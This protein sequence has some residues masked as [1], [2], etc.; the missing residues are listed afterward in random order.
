VIGYRCYISI[1]TMPEKLQTP[2]VNYAYQDVPGVSHS[3]FEN[4]TPEDVMGPL[5]EARLGAEQDRNLAEQAKR[6]LAEQKRRSAP[7]RTA[8]MDNFFATAQRILHP[9]PTPEPTP[10]PIPRSPLADRLAEQQ[11]ADQ[12]WQPPII[13]DP[14]GL[15]LDPLRA[16]FDVAEAEAQWEAQVAA[17]AARREAI[18]NSWQ[19][20]KN[21]VNGLYTQGFGQD[22]APKGRKANHTVKEAMRSRSSELDRESLADSEAQH[23]DIAAKLRTQAETRDLTNDET[24]QLQYAEGVASIIA[25][26]S[27]TLPR[28]ERDAF[29]Q[30][31]AEFI[32]RQG[33]GDDT[34]RQFAAEEAYARTLRRRKLAMRA[35]AIAVT[36]ASAYFV[37]R[38]F[39]GEHVVGMAGH[40]D[41]SQ[42]SLD[43]YSQP[44]SH[45]AANIAQQGNQVITPA[46]PAGIVP[47]QAGNLR[48]EFGTLTPLASLPVVKGILIAKERRAEA[49][50]K[51]DAV[52]EERAKK[53]IP[54]SERVIAS[55]DRRSVI[56]LNNM[57]HPS[58]VDEIV[59]GGASGS[60]AAQHVLEHYSS[61]IADQYKGM[62]DAAKLA[63]VN[64]N[65]TALGIKGMGLQLQTDPRTG[66]V[67]VTITNPD[68]NLI[69]NAAGHLAKGD[70]YELWAEEERDIRA[71][72][73]G[74][75]HSHAHGGDHGGHGHHA[76]RGLDALPAGLLASRAAQQELATMTTLTQQ[77]AAAS[78]SHNLPG[79]TPLVLLNRG[80][81]NQADLLLGQLY[82]SLPDDHAREAAIQAM[83]LSKYVKL[84][85]PDSYNG[86]THSRFIVNS[87][88]GNETALAVQLKALYN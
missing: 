49:R 74:A 56:L 48:L 35:G 33:S 71:G 80:I 78:P 53:E 72:V 46:K 73:P 10:R 63:R 37:S 51:H 57:R 61:L 75:K 77:A 5:M 31:V 86:L 30:Q 59:Y 54:L 84:Q 42:I 82:S 45:T 20:V 41:P 39:G 23:R 1:T 47:N 88:A 40:V 11:V 15:E 29:R 68:P 25:S 21:T 17:A 32:Q 24:D 70:S 50:R 52:T 16:E 64:R 62:N 26:M 2:I 83:G 9:E 3:D 58:F 12:A 38:G 8:D 34:L 28:K 22:G 79:S 87:G 44:L 65:L 4:I 43:S 67:R 7:Q 55:A 69:A 14:T 6:E 18:N 85:E 66:Y 36:V 60:R 13:D 76:F 27:R 81:R 19:N